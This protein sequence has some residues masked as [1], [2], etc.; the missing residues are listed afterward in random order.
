M[1]VDSAQYAAISRQMAETNQFL[2]VQFGANDYLDKPPFLFWVSSLFFKL[3]GVSEFS[4]KVGS[5]LFTLL[6][7]FSTFRLGKLLYDARTGRLAAIILYSCQAFFLFN[8]DV[9]TDTILTGAVIFSLWML[10]EWL[11]QNCWKWLLGAAFGIAA[12]MMAKGPVGL[13]VP[14]L[15]IAS[16]LVGQ[17]RWRDFFRWQYLVL[18]IL[19]A[20]LLAPMSWGLYQQFDAHPDKSVPIAVGEGVEYQRNVSG[21]KFYYWTQSFGRITGENSWKNEAGPFFFVENFLWAFLPWALIFILAFVRRAA[22]ILK[23][24]KVEWLSF[25][26]FLL[27]FLILSMSGYK[28]PHY[29]FVLFP[30]AAILT[31]SVW[32]RIFIGSKR[33]LSVIW[34]FQILIASFSVVFIGLLLVWIFPRALWWIWLFSILIIGFTLYFLLR[35]RQKPLRILIASALISV[36]VNFAMNAWFYPNIT[37]FQLGHQIPQIVENEGIEMENLSGFNYFSFAAIFY[38]DGKMEGSNIK[39]LRERLSK[40][41]AT[42]VI[43][44]PKYLA[45]LK[46]HFAVSPLR[47]FQ[48]YP[49]TLLSPK[50]LNPK[51]RVETLRPIYLLELKNPKPSA[52]NLVT[53][54]N[55]F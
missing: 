49:V 33:W 9:R 12:A 54:K 46:T 18:A 15:A 1:D 6:G 30:L 45:E 14:V 32:Q 41:A 28:L 51:T 8:N 37:E 39:E 53:P 13:M 31:A 7:V 43:T 27:P 17:R 19:V 50:F 21:L 42:Y 52:P 40:N 20:V 11:R 47:V 5:F 24:S 3:L 10:S 55:S 36:A 25:G 2:Q 22:S 29:I 23:R 34:V 26:G 4:F 48:S 35:F 16:F 38:T 44:E